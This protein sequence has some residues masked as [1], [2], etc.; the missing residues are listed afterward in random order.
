MSAVE[1]YDI[2]VIGLGGIGSATAWYAARA[3]RS[4]IGLE[5]FALG[6]HHHGASHDHSRIIRHSYHTEHYVRLTRGAYDA[7]H[8]VEAASGETCVNVTGGI[9]LFP[10]GAAIDID[11]YR[12]AMHAAGIGFDELSASEAMARWPTWRIAAGTE[13]LYQANT[14]IVSPAA[15]VPLLQRLAT[16]RGAVLRGSTAVT[17]IEPRGDHV[18][19]HIMD[20]RE[21]RATQVVIAAD[22]WTATLIEPLGT[23]LPLTVTREQVTYYDTDT[24]QAF[25]LGNFPVWIWMDDPSFYGFPTFGRPGVKIAQ[26]CGGLPVDPDR[27]GFDPDPAILARTDAFVASAFDGRLGPALSTTTCLYTLTPDRDFVVD[28]L[29]DH[30][31]VHVALGAGHGYKFVA[32]FGRTLAALAA[33]RDP[34]C[35]ITPFRLDRPALTDPAWEANWL[36]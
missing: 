33:G 8:E 17:S 22:A 19:L 16:D 7:W 18:T 30:P 35:D 29:P 2:A 1:R 6:G 27:R 11:T 3:G 25:E 4:V 21:I 34:G 36:V 28:A 14:G 24:P 31:N 15:T 23:S 32:W 12:D 10:R 9:D 20:G 13:V 26:D 5:R